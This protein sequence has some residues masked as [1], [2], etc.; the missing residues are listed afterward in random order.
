MDAATDGKAATLQ[1]RIIRH[2]D[3]WL[4]FVDDPRVPPTNNQAERD[5]RPLV[6]LRNIIFGH[7]G[8]TGALRMGKLM[9]VGE[10]A[11]RHGRRPT[12]IFYR[13]YTRPPNAVLGY[14][15]A[16]GSRS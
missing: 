3:E 4:V 14:L 16:G 10:T 15:Y 9:T 2:A 8:E 11:K 1:G 7:R 6:V 12:E 13:M 5:L